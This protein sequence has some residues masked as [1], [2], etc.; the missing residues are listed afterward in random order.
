MA[1]VKKTM[2]HNTTRRLSLLCTPLMLVTIFTIFMLVPSERVMGAVQRLFYVHVATAIVS[3]LAFGLVLLWSL[4]YLSTGR[5]RFDVWQSAAAEI[6]LLFCSLALITGMIWGRSAW[7]T[8]FR[9]EPRLVTFLLLWFIALAMAL[10]RSFGSLEHLKSHC[11]VLGIV[12]ALTVP[13]VWLSVKLLP[14]SEQLHPVV[15]EDGG[16]RHQGYL[17]GLGLSVLTLTIFGALVLIMRIRIGVMEHSISKLQRKE[18][19]K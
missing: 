19:F 16:L 9:W 15:I 11:A 3:Y 18:I 13:L 5:E 1:T 12:G 17:Y 10:L 8:W 14:Y 6:A 7:N 2:L 4:G